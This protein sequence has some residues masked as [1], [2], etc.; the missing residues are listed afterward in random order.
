VRSKMPAPT[1]AVPF[2]LA[3]LVA[4]GMTAC[5]GPSAP[6]PEAAAPA[7]Q[8]A[9]TTGADAAAAEQA[10]AEQAAADQAAAEL[11]ARE[12]ELKAREVELELRERE[13]AAQK[14]AATKTPAP[15]KVASTP[16]PAEP[17][18][19]PA[20]VETPPPPPP[21]PPVTIPAGT[22]LSVKLNS[23]YSTKTTALGATVN[24]ELASDLV[25]DGRSVARAGAPISGTVT[26]V[27]SGSRK[28]GAVP[29]L[30]IDFT[31]LVVADG[32]TMPVAIRVNQKGQSEKGRDTAKVA[33]GT[34]AGA[35]I[36]HQINSDKGAV[37]GGIVGG[38][39]GA[40]GAMKTG[41]EVE[42]PA[43]SVLTANVRSA[44][45]YDGR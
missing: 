18:T 7:Q 43:G 23:D 26:E 27:T 17:V 45:T 14:A 11:A 38:A 1:S 12:K 5:G 36:G 20:P 44:F 24:A 13:L 19:A 35:I 9:A 30:K 33:G 39:A 41:T 31:R 42:I 34:A 2:M 10:A 8:T 37:I 6:A 4:L 16:K 15:A 25:V 21:P 22:Q 29:A 32:S 3:A 28:I 40:V